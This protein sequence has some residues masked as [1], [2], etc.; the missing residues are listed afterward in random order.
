MTLTPPK[1]DQ[2]RVELIEKN[3]ARWTFTSTDRSTQDAEFRYWR[4]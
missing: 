4:G 1:P 3:L 2:P